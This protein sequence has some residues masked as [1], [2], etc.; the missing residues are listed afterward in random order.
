MHTEVVEQEHRRD[1]RRRVL[2]HGQDQRLQDLVERR[3]GG[4]HF[5][6]TVFGVAQ[7]TCAHRI[8]D[9]LDGD[10]DAL[11]RQWK[12]LHREGAVGHARIARSLDRPLSHLAVASHG[13]KK[14]LELTADSIRQDFGQRLTDLVGQRHAHNP[15]GGRVEG[16]QADLRNVVGI[17]NG[18]DT[19]PNL[20][21]LRHVGIKLDGLLAPPLCGHVATGAQEHRDLAVLTNDISFCFELTNG[22]VGPENPFG[23]FERLPVRH[24]VPNELER[25]RAIFGMYPRQ[26]RFEVDWDGLRFESINPVEL[27]RPGND[28]AS[29]VPGPG[30]D[31][32]DLLDGV[33]VPLELRSV[34]SSRPSPRFLLL[35]AARVHRRVHPPSWTLPPSAGWAQT[36]LTPRLSAFR[37]TAFWVWM[38]GCRN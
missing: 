26:K 29:D 12:G 10:T 30:T 17:Q 15:L 2:F 22:S 19:Q 25:P 24:R 14:R 27:V 3:A 18:P 23:I 4:D 38:G 35:R 11:A 20:D 37:R 1:H 16:D 33:E 9:V 31:M 7:P 36:P 32:R 8:G 5:E 21:V 34:A 6:Q 13:Q 28:I